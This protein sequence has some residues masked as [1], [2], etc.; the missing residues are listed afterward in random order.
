MKRLLLVF[1]AL[2]CFA[3]MFAQSPA[4][5]TPSGERME[6]LQKRQT[7]IENSLLKN[8]RFRNI[9]PS[10]MGGRAVDIAAN[11]ADPTEFYVAYATGGLWYTHNNGQ[12]FTPV[13]DTESVITIGAIAVNWKDHILWVGTG[14]AN[15]SRSSYAGNGIYKSMDSGKTWQWIGLPESQHIGKIILH[16]SDPNTAYVAVAGHLYSPNPERGVYKTADGGKTWKKILYVNDKTGAIDLAIDPLHPDI[17]YASM[18]YKMRSAWNFEGNGK[19]SGI[20]KSTDGG[21]HWALLEEPGSGLPTGEG[22]GRIGLAVYPGNPQII[23]A[24]VDNNF[25]R[26][27]E[28]KD[29]TKYIA[30]DF[31]AMTASQFAGLD[32]ARLNTFLRSNDFPA[33]Y[34]EKKVKEMVASGKIKPSALYDYLNNAEDDLY[35]TPIIGAEVYRSDDGGQSW[36][37]TNQDFLSLYATYGYY[38]GKIWV[39]PSNPDKI[40]IAG[41]SLLM[42][43]DGGRTFSDIDAANVH[44][45]HHAVWFDP[46]RDSHF[47]NGNDGGLAITYDNGRHWFRCNTPAVGQFYSVVTDD[48]RPYNVYGGLQDNG[49]WWG[50]SN[51]TDNMEWYAEGNYPFKRL[52]GG[53]G[54]QVQ[55]DTRDN[56]TVYSGYQFGYYARNQRNNPSDYKSIHPMPDLGE[57]SLHWNWQSPILL[58]P[59]NQDIFY[60]GSDKFH[61]S[62]NK[63]DSMVTL[64]GDLTNDGFGKKGNVPYGTITAIS[65]SPLKF[66]LLY[67][68]TD[69]GNIQLSAD[70]GSTWKKISEKLPRGLWVSRVVASAYKEGRIY[71][72]LNGYRYDNFTPYLYK[73]ENN[74]NDWQRIGLNLP[75][76]P[77]NVVREDPKNEDIL[78]VGTDNGVYVSIDRGKTF[79]AMMGGLPSVPVHDMAIQAGA[80]ELVLATHGRSIYVAGLGEI[81]KLPGVINK[82]LAVFDINAPHYNKNWGRK[83]DERSFEPSMQ[84]PFFVKEGGIITL[85][86]SSKSGM[87]LHTIKDTADAGFNYAAYNLAIDSSAVPG[88]ERSLTGKYKTVPKAGNGKY[89]LLPGSYQVEIETAG[90]MKET[91]DF[92]IKEMTPQQAEEEAAAAARETAEDRSEQWRK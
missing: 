39:S 65:E 59:H 70:D 91:K 53:D 4:Q 2:A 58:S 38:F 8:I 43:T 23:Y 73:S 22:V 72:S 49:V 30:R 9:G 61:R 78:Y 27:A 14:E 28:K 35:D 29:T 83:S 68:G 87:L 54:M 64:S 67:L 1:A 36:K 88:F 37:K 52:N 3:P 81:Q 76:G 18:W 12:S 60:M 79:M 57:K 33:K 20:Y 41:I 10:V 66:G 34:D 77:V 13:F 56:N 19:T 51:N 46:A 62:M 75:E 17:V 89:Y 5:S 92:S 69:D 32:S 26:K 80:N 55:V 25:H 74:G 31:K 11:P 40:I 47:I 85:Q 16:P 84:I 50:P 48:A 44:G 6:G 42:S 21:D 82:T 63:A 45:D 86:I 15:S 7:L 24:I 71:A 90:G